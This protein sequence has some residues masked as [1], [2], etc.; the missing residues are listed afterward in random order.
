MR[1]F[2]IFDP[3]GKVGEIYEVNGRRYICETAT[4]NKVGTKCQNCDCD[5]IVT[6]CIK[7]PECYLVQYKLVKED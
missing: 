7:M 1:E 3:A 4:Q 6:D 2:P 5:D